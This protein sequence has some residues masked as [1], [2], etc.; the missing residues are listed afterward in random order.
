[1]ILDVFY[2]DES[3]T[4]TLPNE[5]VYGDYELHEVQTAEGYFL[6]SEAVPFTVDGKEEVI[7][8]EKI[9]QGSKGKKSAFRKQE[10][11]LQE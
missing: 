6:G 4:L 10:I 8:V 9:Q 11:F 7:T 3:G 2:T 5:L 1:M